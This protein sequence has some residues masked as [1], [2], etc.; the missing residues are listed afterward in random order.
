[1]N[2]TMLTRLAALAVALYLPA[3]T[4]D[5]HAATPTANVVAVEASGRPGHY[6]FSVRI[7]SPDRGCQQYANW[8]EVLSERGEL[9]YRRILWHSHTSEQPFERSG[10]PVN[11]AATQ[12]VW[13]RAH[14]HPGGYGGTALRGSVQDGFKPAAAPAGFA[15]GVESL[16]PQA[17]SCAF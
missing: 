16:A 7:A 4:P 8:W 3:L 6:D 15:A 9:L 17:E 13:V 10:G 14:M 11:I 5:A 2:R 1:M 12:V